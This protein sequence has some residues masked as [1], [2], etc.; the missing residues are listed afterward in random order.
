MTTARRRLTYA[1][2]VAVVAAPLVLVGATA[3]FASHTTKADVASAK[4]KLDAL[5][6]QLEVIVERYNG[7][8][9][10]LQQAQQQLTT[11]RAQ[12]QK[13]QAE[14]AAARSRLSES[15]AQ[16]YMGM[17][18][19]F[20]LVLGAQD[21]TQLSDRLEYLGTVAQADSDL[22]VA[23][24]DA[25]QKAEW[26]AQQYSNAVKGAQT[27][28]DAVNAQRDQISGLLAQAQ[29][30]YQQ[31]NA[32]YRSYLAAQRAALQAQRARDNAAPTAGAG[33]GSGGAGTTVVGGS[34]GSPPP[35]PTDL[36]GAAAAIA[37]AKSVLGV[38]YVFASADPSVGFDCS[39]LTMW[40]WA[41]AG[42][43]LPHSSAMQYAVLPHVDLSQIQP[44]DLLFFY[45]PI[46]HVAMYLGGGIIIHATHPGPGG[47]VHIESLDPIWRPLLVGAARP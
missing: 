11:A 28:L 47:E 7:D 40:S 29:T 32:H 4:A 38:Q 27:Q 24:D 26:A 8:R 35:P 16:A 42:I 10:Q 39:G 37:A 19:E 5:N 31:T 6:H 15:A 21:F 43:S 1:I 44:G 14:A 30:L 34:G 46:S 45:S 3:S 18:S 9:V 33:G 36:S 25:H 20:D 23:A 12:M 17:G 41:H 13:A 22:A 2:V